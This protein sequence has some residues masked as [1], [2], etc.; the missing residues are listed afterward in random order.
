MKVSFRNFLVGLT[1]SFYILE[2][3]EE[4]LSLHVVLEY[5]GREIHVLTSALT[6]GILL[7]AM[8]ETYPQ[9]KINGTVSTVV[10]LLYFMW[11][12]FQEFIHGLFYLDLLLP[13]GAGNPLND[14]VQHGIAL[15]IPVALVFYMLYIIDPDVTD[16]MVD[17]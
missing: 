16:G 12:M 7:Y 14:A 1:F 10:T 9:Q 6:A 5:F 2:L 4:A 3:V 15:I 11:Q 17:L 8:R 13:F